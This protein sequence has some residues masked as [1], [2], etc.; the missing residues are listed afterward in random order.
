MASLQ[1]TFFGEHRALES[2]SQL[3]DRLE[4]VGRL[5]EWAPLVAV[6]DAVWRANASTKASC[7]AKPWDS[8]LML[9]I[10]VLKRLYN[11]SDEAMEY[12]LRDRLSFMRFVGL[13]LCEPVPDSRTIWLY[14][15]LLAK[16]GAEKKLFETFGEQLARKGLLVKEGVMVDA[17]FVEVP[18]Q[19]NSREDNALVKDGQTPAA[20]REQPRKL[21][22]KDVDA[23]WTKKGNSVHY[24]YK[25]HV[26]VGRRS[27]LIRAYTVTAAN[28][29][30][31]QAMPGLVTR[32]DAAVHADTAY[33]GAPI[34]ADLQSKGVAN[35]IHEK[36]TAAAPLDA[37]QKARNKRKSKVRARVEHVFAFMEGSLG[38]L[39]N[40][41]IGAGRNA[42]Q[43]GL[44]NL[45]YNICRA[46]QLLSG[47]A[48]LA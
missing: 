28:I 36:A 15:D 17:S 22:Q 1:Y 39:Y 24:G 14:S 41:C 6:V 38:G 18:K 10:L 21:A 4:E 44:L 29:H 47:R 20:W 31:S 19:R 48:S 42:F 25:N 7:G 23:R 5:V 13:G 43:V 2:L 37:R 16:A 27:K 9:R 35:H 11:L 32:G 26:K 40:R 8:G 12:Q 33:I 46:T 30:D 3:G 34:A 45:C